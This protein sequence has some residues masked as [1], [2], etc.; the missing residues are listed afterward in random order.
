MKPS[1]RS[2]AW[3]ARGEECGRERQREQKHE[4]Q[5]KREHE[6]QRE[7][8]RQ[9]QRERERQ[10]Q[11]ECQRQRQRECQRKRER[12]RRCRGSRRRSHASTTLCSHERAH[13]LLERAREAVEEDVRSVGQ[14][15]QLADDGLGDEVVGHEHATLR[16]QRR[17]ST[18]E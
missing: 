10:R 3:K 5:R 12:Q 6:C 14:L 9:R 18:N 7:R 2:W 11:R 16:Q 4:C 1:S 8:Q 17:A 15:S 13:H